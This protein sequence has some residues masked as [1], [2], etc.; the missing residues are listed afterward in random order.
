M[1][2]VQPGGGPA[3]E[4]TPEPEQDRDPAGSTD[5]SVT[6]DD[7]ADGGVAARLPEGYEPV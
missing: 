3:D 7:P 5:P 6:E 4:S 1:P 2:D